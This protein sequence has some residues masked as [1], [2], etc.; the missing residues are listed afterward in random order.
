MNNLNQSGLSFTQRIGLFFCFWIFFTIIG[1][2][3]IGFIIL[4]WGSDSTPALR[5][6]TVLQDIIIFIIPSIAT[7]FLL[8]RLP[9]TFLSAEKFPSAKRYLLT[10]ATLIVSIPTMNW[11]ID[12]N[13]NLT[14]PDSLQSIELWMKEREEL[15]VQQIGMILGGTKISDLMMSILIVGVLTGFSEEL[16]FR[17]ALQKILLSKPMNA[18]Y[19]IWITAF[20]FS[21]MHL[22]FYG[23]VPRMLL[24]AFFGYLVW[25]SGSLWLPIVAHTTNNVITIIF[26]W[27]SKKSIVNVDPN[28]LGTTTSFCDVVLAVASIVLTILFI[29]YLRKDL[30]TANQTSCDGKQIHGQD[31]S[32]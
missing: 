30:L 31:T 25:W 8:S 18:H 26:S 22:Q 9:A 5:I 23:F 24:G 21:A 7:A 19:A 29:I 2:L 13:A 14:F 11:I 16:F 27:M 6:A 17:G 10:I 28:Q 3:I 12:I 20:V 4:K 32:L 15:A 1:S